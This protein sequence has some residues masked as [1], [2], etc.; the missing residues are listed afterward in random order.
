MGSTDVALRLFT[1]IRARLHVSKQ[2]CPILGACH[3]PAFVL[4]GVKRKVDVEFLVVFIQIVA[5]ELITNTDDLVA[6]N[7]GPKT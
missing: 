2:E 1:Q 3:D 5:R 7:G 4:P 6:L